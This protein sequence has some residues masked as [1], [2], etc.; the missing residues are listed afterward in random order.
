MP[1]EEPDWAGVRVGVLEVAVGAPSYL[2]GL[3][4]GTGIGGPNSSPR[5]LRGM[6]SWE[7]DNQSNAGAIGSNRGSSSLPRAWWPF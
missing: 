2:G 5:R 1:R 3:S 6:F 4:L 7:Q